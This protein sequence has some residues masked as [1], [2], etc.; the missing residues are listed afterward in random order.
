MQ[1]AG[2]YTK[3]FENS[4][5]YAFSDGTLDGIKVDVVVAPDS[6]YSELFEAELQPL[7]PTPGGRTPA[8]F[9][10]SCKGRQCDYVP[11]PVDD[12]CRDI[13]VGELVEV[14]LGVSAN[15]N[16]RTVD[17]CSVTA[18]MGVLV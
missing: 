5:V 12:L 1:S 17:N 16:L 9:C 3:V 13:D 4:G 8:K 11:C 2:I 14:L 15:N 6:E 10:H 7:D 18:E